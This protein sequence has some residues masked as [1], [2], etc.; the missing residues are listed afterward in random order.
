MSRCHYSLVVQ[1]FALGYKGH[2][3]E[4][5]HVHFH[6]LPF[7]M[8]NPESHVIIYKKIRIR[9]AEGRRGMGTSISEYPY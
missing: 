4:S 5:P 1:I 8:R 9:A 2:G 3:F 7:S 6:N